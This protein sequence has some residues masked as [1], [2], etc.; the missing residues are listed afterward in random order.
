MKSLVAWVMALSLFSQLAGAAEPKVTLV[1]GQKS[2]KVL[3]G[4]DVFTV[5]YYG[6]DR[7]K[8]FFQPVTGPGGYEL[9]K[10]A[11]A[12]AKP[13]S[14]GRK[15][16]VA[17]ETATLSGGTG[18]PVDVHYGDVL[19]VSKVD[20]DRLWIDE[21]QGWI[22]RTEVA[23]MAAVVTRL[24]NDEKGPSID[25][26]SGDKYDHPHHKG[27][28]FSV[29]EINEHRHWM[30]GSPV[31]TQSVKIVETKGGVPAIQF[32]NLWLDKDGQPL[33]LETTVASFRPERLLTYETVLTPARKEIHIGDTKEGFFAIRLA[34]TMREDA[35]GG[36]VTNAD[37]LKGTA[38]AW[39]KT[40]AWVN[41][42]GPV[43]GHV[44]GV[45]L[46]DGAQNPWPSRYHVRGYGLFAI[47]PF[48]DGAY[49]EGTEKKAKHSRTL[50][51]GES[52]SFK[53]GAWIH[54]PNVT[55]EQIHAEYARF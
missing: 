49:T 42:D 24:I 48:G 30:E 23:P 18:G 11:V 37:G 47:N 14:V 40:S 17:S 31:K 36:P 16:F 21:K 4:D 26:Y 55:P 5:F 39:G 20:G 6:E 22:A 46:M 54:G 2:V 28:W 12:K 33:L 1:Q 51:K 34:G 3:I 41:Y 43:D 44:F 9:L 19:E 35:K 13:D 10:E 45:T 52:L 38:E 7:N 25:K 8:P 32:E 15:V 50:K 29:D 53:Y 27:I